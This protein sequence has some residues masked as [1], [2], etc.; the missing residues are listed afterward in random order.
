VL[1]EYMFLVCGW[2]RS[3]ASWQRSL[4]WVAVLQIESLEDGLE[5]VLLG[6]V[7]FPGGTVSVDVEAKEVAGGSRVG[8]CHNT[9][10]KWYTSSTYVLTVRTS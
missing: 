4:C 3:E 1:G 2:N 8:A 5:V 9:I 6:H 10:T 7:E